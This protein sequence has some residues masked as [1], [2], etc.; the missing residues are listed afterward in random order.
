[1]GLRAILWAMHWADFSTGTRE[2]FIDERQSRFQCGRVGPSAFLSCDGEPSCGGCESE[3]TGRTGY[4]KGK[5]GLGEMR[6]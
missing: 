6:S 4:S 1:M 2:R 3:R 5:R